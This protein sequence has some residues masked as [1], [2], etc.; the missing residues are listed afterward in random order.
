MEETRPPEE[1]DISGPMVTGSL[2]DTLMTVF[3]TMTPL[4]LCFNLKATLRYRVTRKP[5]WAARGAEIP[6][7]AVASERHCY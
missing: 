3:M 2:L 7:K 6:M 1:R 5:Y 4:G